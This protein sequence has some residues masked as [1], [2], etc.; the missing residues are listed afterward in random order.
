M[1]KKKIRWWAKERT[2]E[3]KKN[4]LIFTHMVP[5]EKSLR[6]DYNCTLK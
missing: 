6:V 5:L 3:E 4:A 1:A 2:E